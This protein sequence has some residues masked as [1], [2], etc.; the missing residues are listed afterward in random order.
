MA[1]FEGS[2]KE[3]MQYL[4]SYYR[5]KVNTITRS[6]K[7]AV[8]ECEHCQT[9]VALEAAHVH[10]K[11]R[12]AMIRSILQQ[13]TYNG[14][15]K[16]DLQAFDSLFVQQH[17]PLAETV[18]IL[19]RTCHGSCDR[20]KT[21]HTAIAHQPA[22]A[23]AIE[24]VSKTL[25]VNPKPTS[26]SISKRRAMQLVNAQTVYDLNESNTIFANPY[27]SRPVWWLEPANEKFRQ[28][29][30]IILIDPPR[31]QFFYF[32]IPAGTIQ[33]PTSHFKQRTDKPSSS[34]FIP[35]S[36]SRFKDEN[37]FDFKPYLVKEFSY[38]S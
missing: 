24:G 28:E 21:A 16:V 33:Q 23:A 6:H 38:S 32:H 25:P 3:F 7:Q 10:G 22:A 29:L 9:T 36:T 19:C 26:L 18:K 1:V 8:G 37:G 27:K 5:I 13:Y 20:A 2:V 12:A 17:E 34:I 35:L 11:E 4:G 30:H 31:Q 15:V 14:L